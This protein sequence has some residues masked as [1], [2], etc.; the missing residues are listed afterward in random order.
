VRPADQELGSHDGS[1]AGFAQQRR[2]GWVLGHERQQFD[3][4]LGG[5]VGQEPDTGGDR[6]QRAEKDSVLDRGG[7]GTG[8][9]VDSV[10]LSG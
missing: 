1:D 7:G 5:L 8:Q 9:P 6:A 3:V 10:E 2:P 4:E